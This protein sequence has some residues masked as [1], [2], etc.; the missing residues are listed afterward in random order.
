MAEAGDGTA[1]RL[2]QFRLTRLQVVNWG[3]FPGYRDLP[4]TSGACCS[5]ARPARGIPSC[6]MPTPSRCCP[7]LAAVQRIRRPDRPRVAS[8]PPGRSP[9]TCAAAGR[10]TTTSTARRSPCTCGRPADLDRGRRHL[11]RPARQDGHRRGR[12]LVHR[13]RDRQ[14]P[15]SGPV[16]GPRRPLRP[17]GT[18]S[19]GAGRVR[20]RPSQ[21]YYPPPATRFPRSETEYTALLARHAGLGADPKAA[22][23]LLGKAKALKNV[24]D[25]NLFIRDNMLDAPSTYAAATRM[26]EVFTP[27]DEAYRTAERAQDQQ[28]VLAPVPAAWAAYQASGEEAALLDSLDDGTAAT[29][30]GTPASGCWNP[31]PALTEARPGLEVRVASLQARTAR[32]ALSTGPWTT[33]SPGRR[34]LERLEPT[35]SGPPPSRPPGMAA[36][37]G[38]PPRR[39]WPPC[40]AAGGPRGVPRCRRFL[41]PAGRLSRLTAPAARRRRKASYAAREAARRTGPG[42]ELERLRAAKSMIPPRVLDR[43]AE[44]PARPRR[45]RRPALRGRLVDVADGEDRSSWPRKRSCAASA[46]G[47]L[48]PGN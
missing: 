45:P 27:L 16:P 40:P 18:G 17:A 38:T 25:L 7:G 26:G 9:T 6:W 19:L 34:E 37:S 5:P 48:S 21:R 12:P 3:S 31:P 13:H 20:R 23:A 10:R 46:C 1:V 44:S 33:R 8:R 11:R 35:T 4:S 2:G 43:R 47:C 15:P 42:R 14:R 36:T 29:G 24:G 39:L 41:R 22:L 28:P 30:C 32:P